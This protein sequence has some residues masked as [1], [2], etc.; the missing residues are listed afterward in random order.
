MPPGRCCQKGLIDSLASPGRG[1]PQHVSAVQDMNQAEDKGG[2]GQ[3]FTDHPRI[4]ALVFAVELGAPTVWHGEG[5]PAVSFDRLP[6]VNCTGHCASWILQKRD[7]VRLDV[8]NPQV[9]RVKVNQHHVGRLGLLSTKWVQ[10][11]LRSDLSQE[12]I[13]SHEF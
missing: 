12:E 4:D 13:A 10:G 3:I 1:S 6:G 9:G 5:Y 2:I 11:F 8:C 7:A